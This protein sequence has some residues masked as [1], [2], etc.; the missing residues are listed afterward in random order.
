[1]REV[2]P[3]ADVD[4]VAS[5]LSDV[6][7]GTRVACEIRV[8]LTSLDLRYPFSEQVLVIL[9]NPHGCAVRCGKPLV[10]GTPV[11]FEGLPANRNV[12]ARVVNCIGFG[13][14]DRFWLLGLSLDEP[15]NVWGV[16]PPPSDW[17]S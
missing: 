9:V 11:T 2:K 5:G 13:D 6:R 16:E 1:M 3:T 14:Y 8:I 12:T 7:R 4:P 17:S 10:V 15:G